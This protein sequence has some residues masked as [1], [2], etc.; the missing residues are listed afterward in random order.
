[1]PHGHDLPSPMHHLHNGYESQRNM[2]S[3]ITPYTFRTTSNRGLLRSSEYDHID[4]NQIYVYEECYRY[5]LIY[6]F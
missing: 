2:R 5:D 1:V 6:S 4:D 3:Q